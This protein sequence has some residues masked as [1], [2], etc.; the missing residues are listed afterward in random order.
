[1]DCIVVL[2]IF[3]LFALLCMLQVTV[4]NFAIFVAFIS[5]FVPFS[6]QETPLQTT[7]HFNTIVTIMERVADVVVDPRSNVTT[8][9]RS[10]TS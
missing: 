2:I 6:H 10:D 8:T 1:M 3:K 9:V 5:A 4:D 7:L